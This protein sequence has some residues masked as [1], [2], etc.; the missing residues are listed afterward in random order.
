MM[1]G[2]MTSASAAGR[3][4]LL[5]GAGI[6]AATGANAGTTGTVKTVVLPFDLVLQ[7]KEEDFY[8]G[9][10]KPS[11][12]EQ[13]R[14]A[15][16]YAEL[17]K[18]LAADGRHQLVDIVPIA[19][20]IEAAAP[21][22]DCNGCEIDLAKKLDG[23]ILYTGLVDKASDTLLNMRIMEIDVA[24]GQLKRAGNVV[25]QGNTDEAWTRGVRW[26]MKNKLAADT[27]P[28]AKP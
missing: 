2:L 15:T 21:I 3:L 24:S 19:K 16:I 7:K 13:Q 1:G 4:A 18:I 23:Q 8:I 22:V 26:L 6:L 28:E 10:S 25:I 20:E 5:I 9:P 17:T 14:L 27:T 12:A 11:P